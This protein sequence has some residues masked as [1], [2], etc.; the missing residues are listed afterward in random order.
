MVGVAENADTSQES[1]ITPQSLIQC[2][3]NELEGIP[4]N[5]WFVFVTNL[6]KLE[7]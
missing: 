7:F 1:E 5:R 3:K 2:A 4:L 6:Y